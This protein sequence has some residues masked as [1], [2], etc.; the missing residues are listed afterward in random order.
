M[1]KTWTYRSGDWNCICDVCG[2]KIKA[3]KI[4]HRWD[5]L[6]VCPEDFEHRHS[7]DFIKVRQ[8]KIIV[9]FLRPR[10]ADVFI[11]V[12]YVVGLGCVPAN[13]GGEA[14]FAA[15]DC[16]RAGINVFNSLTT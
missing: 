14:D 4:K 1:S 7:Q 12:S 6:L 8:D 9:P 15:A 2:K 16:A 10:P 3:S 13:S 11:D 5:G